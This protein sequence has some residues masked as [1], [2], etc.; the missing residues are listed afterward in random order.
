MSCCSDPGITEIRAISLRPVIGE[1]KFYCE[2]R[3]PSCGIPSY[4]WHL[5]FCLL[6]SNFLYKGPFTLS[7][8]RSE[9]ENFLCLLLPPANEVRGLGGIGQP[10]SETWDTMGYSQQVGG[11]HPTGMHSCS[12][13]Q[14]H[15][16]FQ[17]HAK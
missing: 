16:T 15:S 17:Y 7:E 12:V 3:S 4:P 2:T 1:V 5:R 14:F 8:S 10:P 13:K 11:T 6:H 9:S